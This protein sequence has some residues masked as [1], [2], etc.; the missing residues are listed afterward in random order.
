MRANV[1]GAQLYFDVEGMGL[2]PVGTAMV[3]KDACFV[4]HGGPGLDHSYFKPWLSPLADDL[5][6]V[7][8]DHR[9]N[10]RSERVALETC[11]IE[12][13][14]DDLEA[15]RELLGLGQVTVLGNSFGG[16]VAQMYAV[17]HPQSVRR[18]ILVSTSP[19][20]EFYAAAEQELARKGTAEQKAV[21]GDVF[22]GR[23]ETDEAFLRWW[24]IMMPLYFAHWDAARGEQMIKRGV[25]NPKVASHMFRHEIPTFDVRPQLNAMTMPTLV[26]AGRHDWVTPVG[27][28][29][30]I[31]RGIPG[32]ELVVF[33]ESGHMP[34]IRGAGGLRCGR[35]AVPRCLSEDQEAANAANSQIRSWRPSIRREWL[36]PG[37]GCGD[38]RN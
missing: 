37:G 11:T 18:L 12:Q 13:M 32:S 35:S 5:Q 3:E 10:G 22:E 15:L 23:I 30:L 9:A 25:D 26:I 34:F 2:T 31:A 29:E 8:V 19:S 33:E 21:A 14:A 27:E 6:L 38:D 16:F 28:S 1:N 4:L 7:Y 20:H 17:R 24:D 36:P